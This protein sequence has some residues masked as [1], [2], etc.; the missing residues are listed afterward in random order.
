[1]TKYKPT[2]ISEFLKEREG[3]YNPA[4]PE[5]LNLQR[6]NKIDFKGEIHLSD[7]SS[8]TNMIVI[9]PGD[10]VISGINV[11]KG[12]I[13]VYHGEC[14]IVATIHYSSYKFDEEKIEIE[15]FKRFLKSQSFVESLKE[16]VKGGIKTEIKPKHFLPLEVCLPDICSQKEIVSFFSRI[17]NDMSDLRNE[18]EQ[19]QEYLKKLRQAILQEAIEGKLTADWRKKNPD[20]ISGEN[21]ALK[22]LETIKLEKDKLVKEGKIKKSKPLDPVTDDEKPF[23]LPGG[24]GWCRP[25][26]L[27]MFSGGGTP[28]THIKE[29]WNGDV[30]WITPKDMKVDNIVA[31][32]INITEKGIQNSNTTFLP[33]NTLIFVVRS[34]ILKHTIPISLTKVPATINQDLKSWTLFVPEMASFLQI[35]IKGNEG[36]LLREV[37]KKGMTVESF[38][39]DK[40]KTCLLP[41]TSI[42]EQSAIVE[43]VDKLMTMVDELE[44]QVTERKEQSEMLMKS[45]LKEAFE[46]KT[47]VSHEKVGAL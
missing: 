20:L 41:L 26:E 25:V 6:L 4:D 35:N 15:Y 3:R 2:R 45:V 21:H 47:S 22:L 23:N 19:Q 30:P 28:S 46:G 1:M 14:P 17:E 11:S 13:A 44:K 12:A 39:F 37:I 43:R 16:Q 32:K 34:G 33:V 38:D 24:W 8:K 29:Y 5:I 9:E 18:I 36:R 42:A 40:F 10:L 7:K 31:S 27:G